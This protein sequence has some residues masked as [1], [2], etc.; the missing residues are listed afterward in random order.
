MG[1][2]KENKLEKQI[3]RT[4]SCTLQ[5]EVLIRLSF[6]TNDNNHSAIVKRERNRQILLQKPF[7]ETLSS[8]EAKLIKYSLN[9]TMMIDD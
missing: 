8:Y 9:Y 7:F 1:K 2:K 6:D 4:I 5:M 3:R